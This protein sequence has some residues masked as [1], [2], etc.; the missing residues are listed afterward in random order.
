MSMT[1]SA[2]LQYLVFSIAD[3]KL[4]IDLDVVDQVYSA[5]EIDPLPE[6]PN[7][8]LG[9][10]NV[11]GAIIVALN[12]RRKLHLQER[13]VELSDQLLI[14]NVDERQFALLI[15]DVK[16]VHQPSH[17]Q[18]ISSIYTS[19]QIADDI[20]KVLEMKDFLSEDEEE[21]LT[22]ALQLAYTNK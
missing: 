19:I 10:I 16:G 4:A 1:V 18:I 9:L 5:V 22:T 7:A 8:V 20:V 15:D 12:L 3:Q 2:K 6:A 11:H 13:A 21:Q 17:D 14:V